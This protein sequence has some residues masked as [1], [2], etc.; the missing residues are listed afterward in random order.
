LEGVIENEAAYH[1]TLGEAIASRDPD[2][3]RRTVQR[4]MQLPAEAEE[5]MRET[6]VGEVPVIPF[7]FGI[8]KLG[9][10]KPGEEI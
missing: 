4:L 6:S 5:A 2:E 10:G 1:R 7:D 9:A 8:L 3:A